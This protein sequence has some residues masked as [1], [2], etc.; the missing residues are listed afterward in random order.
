M[1]NDILDA[2][3][4]LGLNF[5]DKSLLV[6]A[7]T[8][9]SY[10]LEQG[11]PADHNNERLEFLGDGVLNLIAAVYLYRKYPDKQEGELSQLR[12]VLISRDG[13]YRWARKVGIARFILLGAGEEKSG[14]R[15]K[16]RVIASTMEAVTGAIFLD[17]GYEASAKFALR[18]FDSLKRIRITEYKN[19]LQ[20]IVQQRYHEPPKYEV[21]K[22]FGPPHRQKFRVAVIIDGKT[23]ALSTGWSKKEAEID[24]AR[25]ALRKI[26]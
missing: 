1:Q 13:L 17:K 2:E 18:Y 26:K 6:L 19:R 5:Q 4:A 15:K 25:K 23:I 24:A 9:R 7:L 16:K 14:G 22:V 11:L 3:K 20:T 10:A 12:G 8:H 21:L